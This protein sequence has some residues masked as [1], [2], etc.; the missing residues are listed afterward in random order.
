MKM[1]SIKTDIIV[2]IFFDGFFNNHQLI[3]YY[4]WL[5][6]LII[7]YEMGPKVSIR[8]SLDDGSFNYKKK[9]AQLHSKKER[10]FQLALT[11]QKFSYIQIDKLDDVENPFQSV[12]LSFSFSLFQPLSKD[13]FG[14][15]SF[16]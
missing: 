3:P 10:E 16:M 1:K 11:S 9:Q 5:R 7:P 4:Q 2:R 14:D 12:D 13:S 15:F 6:Q 8:Y